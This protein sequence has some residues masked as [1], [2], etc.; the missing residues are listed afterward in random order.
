MGGEGGRGA[1]KRVDHEDAL[2]LL[3]PRGCARG[4]HQQ[5][6]RERHPCTHQRLL[7]L[8]LLTQATLTGQRSFRP[9]IAVTQTPEGAPHYRIPL[10]RGSAIG[11]RD[12]A[13]TSG[14]R[15]LGR[16]PRSPGG[17]RMSDDV[18]QTTEQR[19]SEKPW[20]GR[21]G[22][23]ARRADDRL[24][25]RRAE[26]PGVAEPDVPETHGPVTA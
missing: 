19:R 20:L 8:D 15:R 9:R 11:R 18:E 5:K 23:G 10:T 25:S 6:Q 22:A 1:P 17:D 26:R 2:R 12:G 7:P 4:E 24:V 14:A 16:A 13:A 3:G 21:G